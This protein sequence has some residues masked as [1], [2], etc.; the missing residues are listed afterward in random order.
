MLFYGVPRLVTHIDDE[1]IAALTHAYR[2]RIPPGARILDLMSSWISHLPDDVAYERVAGH[3]MN[4]VELENNRRLTDRIVQD[5]NVEPELPY[6]DGSFD[7]VLNAVSVQYLTRPVAVFR[8]VSRVLRP[9]GEHLVAIS[10]RMFPTKAIY[11]WQSLSPVERPRLVEMYFER[12]GAF[13]NVTTS[14]HSPPNADP[15]WIVSGRR[16]QG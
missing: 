2:D 15:L 5:L 9:G 6:D 3:G 4:A 10:H 13:S 1:T 11:A 16:R 12:S 7:F 14:E 8:S